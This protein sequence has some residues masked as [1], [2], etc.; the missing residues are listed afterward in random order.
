[1]KISRLFLLLLGCLTLGFA[2]KAQKL[3][4]ENSDALP[5]EIEQMY[6]KGLQFLSKSQLSSGGFKD[7]PYGTSPGVVGLAIASM[8]AHGDD[9]NHGPH[10][11]NIKRGLSFIINQQN[12]TTG[13]IGTTMYNH[14]FATLA[15][16]EAYGAVEDDRLGP[17]LEKAISLIVTS[18]K[19]NPRGGWRYSPE[20]TDADT[21]VSGAQMVALFAARN[22]GLAVPETAIQKGLKYFKSCQTPEGGFGYTSNRGPNAAR[23]AIATLVFALAKEKDSATFKK[24]FNYL[25]KAPE[26]S[27]YRQYYL[28]YGAQA[29]F[30]ASPQE[31]NK[32]NRKNITKLKQSQNED[33]SWGG[34]FG[35]TF[36]TSASLLSIALNYRFLPIY[37]R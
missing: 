2:C 8:L 16:A 14:G 37:E 33:G 20:S 24:S 15:L 10:S 26:S 3:F 28:Y 4:E 29:F 35:T 34:Q 18:Q 11:G 5:K 25:R 17:S 9:P 12:K 21:T 22:A 30:H 27:S 36:S 13:Y 23:T 19:K 1:M 7:N 31:W 32:W 6:V